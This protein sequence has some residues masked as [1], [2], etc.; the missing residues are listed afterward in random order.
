MNHS[1]KENINDIWSEVPGNIEILKTQ[2]ME[3]SPTTDAISGSTTI[4]S[5][6]VYGYIADKSQCFEYDEKYNKIKSNFFEVTMNSTLK[7]D[8][9]L[10][11]KNLHLDCPRKGKKSALELFKVAHE[12]YERPVIENNP[13]ITSLIPI[14]ESIITAIQELIRLC[15]K[16]E[17]IGSSYVL[18]ISFIANQLKKDLISDMIVQKWA[19]EWNDIND[20]D[21]SASKDEKISREEWGHKLHRATQFFYSF[22]SGLDPTKIRKMK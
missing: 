6:Y 9:L 16:Q 17:H 2:L 11:L 5:A 20:K 14:R 12:A 7:D 13:D 8:V 22:L 18:K 1:E 19:E 4:S 10:L 21:L 15:P 3:T